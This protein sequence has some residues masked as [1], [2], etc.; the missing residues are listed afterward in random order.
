VKV[1]GIKKG[2]SNGLLIVAVGASLLLAARGAAGDDACGKK[3]LTAARARFNALFQNKK[4]GEAFDELSRTKDRCWAGLGADDRARLASDLGLSAFR[5]GKPDVCLKVL[6]EAPTDLPPDSKAAKALAFNRGLCAGKPAEGGAPPPGTAA[7]K[8]A[9]L[10]AKKEDLVR[11]VQKPSEDP[12]DRPNSSY[13]ATGANGTSS[14]LT[15]DRKVDLNGDGTRELVL[16][17][18]AQATSDA[19]FLLWYFDCGGGAFY[20]LLTE[21]AA[22]VEVGKAAPNGWK[23]IY[24]FNGIVPNKPGYTA[25]DKATYRFDGAHYVSVKTEKVKHRI[26]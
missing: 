6:A 8:A 7:G 15:F 17:D 19:S 9:P 3:D 16:S 20:P 11:I 25:S 21:Y 23:D 26:H 12:E 22:D 5:A 2:R 13:E 1:R 10:C 18:P 24:Y 4:Y 14:S